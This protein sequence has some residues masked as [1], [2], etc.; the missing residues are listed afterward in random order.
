MKH[1]RFEV[2][3]AG[4]QVAGGLR[5]QGLCE[6]DVEGAAGLGLPLDG[7]LDGLGGE[8]VNNGVE[9]AV[10]DGDAEGYGVDGADHRLHGAAVQGFGADQSVEHQVHV[11]GDEA[12]AENGE[13]HDYHAQHLF[14]VHLPPPADGLR[15]P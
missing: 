12:E 5:L 9:A 13:M 11:V 1:L 8:V 15:P 7:V 3:Q 6:L 14:L 10:E 2:P 4:L